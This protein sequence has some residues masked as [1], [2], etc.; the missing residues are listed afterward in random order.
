MVELGAFVVCI[1]AFKHGDDF[2]HETSLPRAK[3]AKT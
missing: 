2:S 1:Y 3:R